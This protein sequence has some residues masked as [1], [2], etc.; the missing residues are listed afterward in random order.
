MN[1]INKINIVICFIVCF[2]LLA[3]FITT[4]LYI[5]IRD[6]LSQ[7]PVIVGKI[8][9]SFVTGITYYYIDINNKKHITKV[10]NAH[11]PKA[12]I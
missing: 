7:R 6:L 10:G 4:L 2:V 12:A 3:S 1:K 5:N 8:D 9:Y 11:N